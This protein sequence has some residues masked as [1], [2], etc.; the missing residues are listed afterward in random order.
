MI[1][2][3]KNVHGLYDFKDLIQYSDNEFT[4]IHLY[5]INKKNHKLDRRK[6]F[7]VYSVVKLWNKLPL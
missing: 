6:H 7:L 2:I 1:E 3:F 5:K 4:R